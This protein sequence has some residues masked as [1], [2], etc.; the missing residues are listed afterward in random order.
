MKEGLK[1]RDNDNA[2]ERDLLPDHESIFAYERVFNG[3]KW[4]I[5]ANMSEKIE[6]LTLGEVDVKPIISSY[7]KD[8]Y[9]LRNLSLR[10]YEAFA[11]KN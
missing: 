9:D 2:R 11:Y 7:E 3:E 5:V 4:T 10:P 6:K 8:I 1:S